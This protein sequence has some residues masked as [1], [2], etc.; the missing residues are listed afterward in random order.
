MTP[1]AR[2]AAAIGVLDD[3]LAGM[4]VEKALLRWSRGSRY[5][6]SKDRAAV[7]DHVFDGWRR[8]RSAAHGGGAQTG[9]GIMI[10]LLREDGADLDLVFTGQGHA[11]AALSPADATAPADQP[12]AA[13]AHDLPDWLWQRFEADLGR[14]AGPAAL[15]LRRRAPVYLRVNPRCADVAT[16]IEALAQ[17]GIDTVAHET[18]DGALRVTSGERAL[19]RSR[20]FTDGLVELQ[21]AS[22]Q[23]AMLRLPLRDGQSVLD[24]CAGGGGKG[25]ALAGRAKVAV[26]AH[27]IS[28]ARMRDIPVRAA[29]AGV[30]IDLA[31]DLGT[32]RYD[33]VL[34]DAPCSGSGTWR[35]DP[36]GKW[37]LSPETLRDLARL[38][39][40][41][42]D[43]ALAHVAPGGSLSYATCSV[44]H[45]EN[46]AIVTAFLERHPLWRLCDRMRRL[47]DEDGDG[48][49]LVRFERG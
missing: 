24:Y 40:R 15:A 36:D 14:E 45:E 13:V 35:R 2:V 22:S 17:E 16:A 29:R 12:Q 11:P 8:R 7:R 42:L 31:E 9:R 32:A 18:V 41:L 33:H 43:E 34:V 26:T 20:A 46:D 37:R 48:F 28:A 5:A 19:S 44:L 10:G 21:D 23:A 25:L 30:R 27:D 1:A 3:C 47:P 49:F 4:P 39:A 38:Q 6:G